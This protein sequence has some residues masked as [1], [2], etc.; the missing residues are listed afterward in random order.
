MSFDTKIGINNSYDISVR[1]DTRYKSIINEDSYI[2]CSKAIE[3]T[4]KTI[5]NMYPSSDSEYISSYITAELIQN[6][7]VKN[8]SIPTM[9]NFRYLIKTGSSYEYLKEKPSY[10]SYISSMDVKKIDNLLLTDVDYNIKSQLT[11]ANRLSISSLGS[12]FEGA[13]MTYSFPVGGI[14][15]NTATFFYTTDTHIKLLPVS[16]F[17]KID[18]LEGMI[19][20]NQSFEDKIEYVFGY[21]DIDPLKIYEFDYLTIDNK[22]RTQFA[23]IKQKATQGDIHLQMLHEKAYCITFS[24][25]CYIVSSDPYMISVDG[26]NIEFPKY[27]EK[28][29][30]IYIEQKFNIESDLNKSRGFSSDQ[31]DHGSITSITNTFIS[32]DVMKELE[33]YN[34]E[35]SVSGLFL[36]KEIEHTQL[37]NAPLTYLPL[38]KEQD[39]VVKE[40]KA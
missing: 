14:I 25:N 39:E 17:I 30:P 12:L 23:T 1:I 10:F 26:V 8:K 36:I 13:W 7:A 35:L 32:S 9:E 29:T 38:F 24:Y 11:K 6:K 16:P 5:S 20:I 34:K 37:Y 2:D 15:D 40:I 33:Y 22:T 18:L 19:H 3:H 21:F 31:F 4:D 28:N 27:V